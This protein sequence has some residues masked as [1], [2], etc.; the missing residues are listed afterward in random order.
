MDR[1]LERMLELPERLTPEAVEEWER[2]AAI[3]TKQALRSYIRKNEIEDPGPA[4]IH[5]M[6]GRY[7]VEDRR[8]VWV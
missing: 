6:T 2:S 1:I 4:V 7:V 8:K 5:A 3:R